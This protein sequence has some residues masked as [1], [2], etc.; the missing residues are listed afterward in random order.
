MH[1][2][3]EEEKAKRAHLGTLF[4]PALERAKEGD[5]EPCRVDATVPDSLEHRLGVRVVVCE[6]GEG[7]GA[8][9]L[10]SRLAQEAK[11]E[12]TAI[13]LRVEPGG[14]AD[15]GRQERS[16]GICELREED[17]VSRRLSR[18]TQAERGTHQRRG[19][20]LHVP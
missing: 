4:E 11:E 7:G 5:E 17:W 2:E 1:R 18:L 16:I 9:Q 14:I 8:G 20:L 3:E 15:Q 13:V 12:R 19:P 10:E 6:S